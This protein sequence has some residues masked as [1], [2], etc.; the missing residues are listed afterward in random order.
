MEECIFC[1]IAG[2]A[3]PSDVV[4]EDDAFLAFRDINPIA[5]QHV[6]V[7]PR[8]HIS[9]L[10]DID[11]WGECRGHALLS[12]IARVAECLGIEESG[13]RAVVNVGPDAGQQVQH[14]HFHVL[15]GERLGGMR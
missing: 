9:S 7:I 8:G 2:G 6:L 4:L 5:Q 13:Y 1:R 14:L 10:N 12:F 11:E 15:G 3:V